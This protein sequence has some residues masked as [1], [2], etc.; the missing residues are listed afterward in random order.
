M[1]RLYLLRHGIAV[2]HGAPDIADDERPLTAKGEKRARQAARGL[3]RLGIQLER[4]V[5]SPLP[6]AFKTARITA[7]VLGLNESLEASEE[8]RAEH[9]A[10]SIRDWLK[11]RA[12]ECL[13]IVGHNPAFEELTA[14]LATDGSA[15][16]LGE[17]RKG[18]V[19]AFIS[20]E[21]DGYELDWIATPRILRGIR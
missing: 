9:S 12:D 14:L 10:E 17:L 13:M 15:R 1:K 3:R 5:T 21:D 20:K 7:E 18:G 11:T 6:R 16:R 4:I 8:L 2:P 19:A